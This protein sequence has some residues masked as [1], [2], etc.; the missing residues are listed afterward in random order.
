MVSRS[1]P[2]TRGPDNCCGPRY[3]PPNALELAQPAPVVPLT[4]VP[5]ASWSWSDLLGSDPALSR[6]TREG[7]ALA[8]RYM[9][10]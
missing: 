1:L 5:S 8:F 6:M 10:M 9:L 4:V 2:T 3:G 7:I